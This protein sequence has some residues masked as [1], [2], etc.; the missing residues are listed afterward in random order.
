VKVHW[1]AWV[2]RDLADEDIWR[3]ISDGTVIKIPLERKATNISVLTATGVC[4]DGA[5]A[6]MGT[7]GTGPDPNAKNRWLGNLGSAYRPVQP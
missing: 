3:L 2:A 1:D 4:R 7:D 5:N 6:S